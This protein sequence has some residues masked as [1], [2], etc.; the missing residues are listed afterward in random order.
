MSKLVPNF[1]DYFTHQY[2]AKRLLIVCYDSSSEI[3]SVLG[4][5][6]PHE[7]NLREAKAAIIFSRIG[8]PKVLHYVLIEKSS[9][10]KF[11][12]PE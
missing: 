8:P 9:L 11:S 10:F 5:F 6:S 4:S 2:S 3:M 7:R 12:T 1:T